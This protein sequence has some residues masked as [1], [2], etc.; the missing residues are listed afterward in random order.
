MTKAI[1]FGISARGCWVAWLA[2]QCDTA[3]LPQKDLVR[4]VSEWGAVLDVACLTPPEGL[5]AA[6]SQ[7]ITASFRCIYLLV[8][9]YWGRSNEREE[10][11]I[12]T[13]SRDYHTLCPPYFLVCCQ[14]ASRAPSLPGWHSIHFWS[15]KTLS[16]ALSSLPPAHL[17]CMHWCCSKTSSHWGS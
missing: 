5:E 16:G 12:T 17:P 6:S 14:A 7:G 1:V 4:G 13:R 15:R 11:R 9:R 8:I 2:S 3:V 10:H